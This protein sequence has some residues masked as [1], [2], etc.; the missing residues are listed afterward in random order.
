LMHTGAT[1]WLNMLK[2][3]NN[4]TKFIFSLQNEC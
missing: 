3:A 2:T 1:L 4:N